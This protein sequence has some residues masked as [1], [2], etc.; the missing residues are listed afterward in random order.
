MEAEGV[1]EEIK[2]YVDRVVEAFSDS[3]AA[4]EE[5]PLLPMPDR[6]SYLTD[7]SQNMRSIFKRL[8]VGTHALI[9]LVIELA[10]DQSESLTKLRIDQLGQLVAVAAV[11]KQHAARFSHDL[12]QGTTLKVIFGVNDETIE[13]LYE[14]CK[15]LFDNQHYYEAASGFSVLTFL[16][17]HVHLFWMG[18][19]TSEYLQGSFESALLAYAMAAQAD[20]SDTLCHIYSA[21]CYKALNQID[22]AIHSLEIALLIAESSPDSSKVKQ[23]IQE[24]I[25]TLQRKKP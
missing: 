14:G 1:E 21:H 15:Y 6:S 12:A 17:P 18:L 24:Q 13:H 2:K 9:S 7:L 5:H 19:G 8:E 11:V 3:L 25:E 16:D 4:N 23:R 20:S 22:R 10:K